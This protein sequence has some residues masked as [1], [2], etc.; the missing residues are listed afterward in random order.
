MS[1]QSKALRPRLAAGQDGV[2]GR[3]RNVRRV[4]LAARLVHQ[5][6]GE[7]GWVIPAGRENPP[8]Q[9]MGHVTYAGLMPLNDA[10]LTAGHSI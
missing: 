10:L 7:D 9:C 6:D 4:A 5:V 3:Q 2:I 8:R 1:V